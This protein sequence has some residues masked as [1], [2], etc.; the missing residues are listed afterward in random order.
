M[1][2]IFD[3]TNCSDLPP[4]LKCEL[5]LSAAQTAKMQLLELL[6]ISGKPL[7]ISQFLVGY[8][9]KYG[10]QKTRSWMVGQLYKLSKAGAIKP[11]GRKGEYSLTR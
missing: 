10:E 6:Q 4:E 8:Y 1:T 11:T 9:R 7:N 5:Y 3:L 2:D